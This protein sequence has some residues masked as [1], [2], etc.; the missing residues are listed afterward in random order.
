MILRLIFA[1]WFLI[2][3]LLFT[4][5]SG[6]QL[7]NERY[8]LNMKEDIKILAG[9]S[10]E[11]R[12][13]GSMG[14][15]Y[16]ALYVAERFDLL[17]LKTWLSGCYFQDFDFSDGYEFPPEKNKFLVSITDSKRGTSNPIDLAQNDF[18]PYYWGGDGKVSGIV[19]DA[20]YCMEGYLSISEA[21]E[22]RH[23]KRQKGTLVPIDL[24][25]RIALVRY[26]APP[27]YQKQ[28]PSLGNLMFEK[29]EMAKAMGAVAVI[30]YDPENK[31]T[32]AP[33]NNLTG[34]QVFI[35]VVFLHNADMAPMLENMKV[36]LQI[37][38]E[39]KRSYGKNV[40]AW[41]DNGAEKTIVIGAHIDHLGWGINNSRH[42]GPPAIHPG[43][44]DN[45]SGVAG[46]LALAEW[47]S[48]STLTRKNYLF[49]GFSAEEKGLIG[50][51]I[52]TELENIS[53]DNIFAMLN[54]DMI[55]RV[56]AYKPEISLLGAGSSTHWEEL[57]ELVKEDVTSKPV[58]DGLSGSDH[59][60]FYNTG[61]PV[62]FFFNGIHDDYHKP[63]DTPEK[64][65]YTGMRDVVEYT[66]NLLSILDTL[67]SL[68]FQKYSGEEPR[69]RTS[70][71]YSLG[72]VPGHGM[73]V[74]GVY[75]QE[76]IRQWA[77]EAAGIKKGD[78][79]VR[80]GDTDIENMHH[81][82]LALSR[83]QEGVSFEVVVV[84][85]GKPK[86]FTMKF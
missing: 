52:F 79:I 75:V 1:G 66:I 8:I 80:I 78:I 19:V 4:T 2:S 6:Q 42:N 70:L 38:A 39:K 69:S 33:G 53:S 61:V 21:K 81:Y 23:S 32:R 36:E 77:A 40:A 3:A 49:V 17:D 84:R 25:G 60:H 10:L 55:G 48:Q 16:A 67:S 24:Q 15:L 63:S 58:K 12:E 64:I 54:F 41:I 50:S 47:L 20:G 45:A 57:L 27:D 13:A 59:Y 44:D 62:L 30:F 37:S 83:I 68:P 34:Q 46:M 29:A 76:V 82:M 51:R 5:L 35:P 7:L 11:G 85:E 18:S 31:L 14:E 43:A 26:D 9:D 73:D 74:K 28:I 72:I 86:I 65:N 22:R 56:D 71:Q